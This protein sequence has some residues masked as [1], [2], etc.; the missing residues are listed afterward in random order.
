MVEPLSEKA[1]ALRILSHKPQ[2]VINGSAASSTMSEQASVVL[3]TSPSLF[4]GDQVE[5]NFEREGMHR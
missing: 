1:H 4:R 3:A 5:S 2:A